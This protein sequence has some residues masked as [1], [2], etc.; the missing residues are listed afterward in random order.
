VPAALFAAV[1]QVLAWVYQLRAAMAGRGAMPAELPALAVP[2][3]LDPHHG[4][5]EETE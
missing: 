4:K 5:Q 2:D 3:E 1:A